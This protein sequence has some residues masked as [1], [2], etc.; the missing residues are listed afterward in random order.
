[1]NESIDPSMQVNIEKRRWWSKRELACAALALCLIELIIIG[2]IVILV[3]MSL[4]NGY[5]GP[6]Q[7]VSFALR[8]TAFAWLIIGPASILFAIVG[9]IWDSHRRLAVA[10]L[11]VTIVVF[12]LCALTQ[13]PV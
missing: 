5:S 3:Q 9:I 1:M 11:P 12:L 2:T 8:I 13:G 4:I 10:A 7:P 6:N